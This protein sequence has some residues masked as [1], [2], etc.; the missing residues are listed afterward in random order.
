MAILRRMVFNAACV[1]HLVEH[2]HATDNLPSTSQLHQWSPQV[3][4]APG[5]LE[6]VYR[7]KGDY[8][9]LVRQLFFNC[10][11]DQNSHIRSLP[12]KVKLFIWSKEG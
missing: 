4:L 7:T 11:K 1:F 6:K 12:K 5:W 2:V 8:T 3:C 10:C 9:S